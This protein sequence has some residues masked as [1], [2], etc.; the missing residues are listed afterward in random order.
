HLEA[1]HHQD[2]TAVH[3]LAECLAKS[4]LRNLAVDLLGIVT[5]LGPED[6]A[7]ADP[8]GRRLVTCTGAAGAL[9]APG[10]GTT[11]VHFSFRLRVGRS[12]STTRAQTHDRLVQLLG[13]LAVL[14]NLDVG[15]LGSL[16]AQNSCA[17]G[18]LG[19]SGL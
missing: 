6:H 3:A 9:L 5:R 11:Q 17:H 14:D 18:L 15:S 19:T 12:A 1:R 8:N 16:N 13:V 7:T 4:E 10:L 2:I